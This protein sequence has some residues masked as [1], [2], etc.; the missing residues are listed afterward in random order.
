MDRLLPDPGAG[1][2]CRHVGTMPP[3]CREA[4]ALGSLSRIG[5]VDA[6]YEQELDARQKR[7]G[8]CVSRDQTEDVASLAHLL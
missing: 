4:I 2:T 6:S 1:P 3:V 5:F 8:R 7:A